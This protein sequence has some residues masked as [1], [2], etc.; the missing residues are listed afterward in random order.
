MCFPVS[1]RPCS[2]A[3]QK[4][5]CVQLY[6]YKGSKVKSTIQDVNIFVIQGV[7]SRKGLHRWTAKLWPCVQDRDPSMVL[8]GSKIREHWSGKGK[9]PF[10]PCIISIQKPSKRIGDLWVVSNSPH[11]FSLVHNTGYSLQNCWHSTYLCREGTLSKALEE[12]MKLS[13]SICN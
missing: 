8:M 6:L 7:H 5:L 11:V 4:L 3:A 13:I 10:N 2:H 9:F 12:T 1:H